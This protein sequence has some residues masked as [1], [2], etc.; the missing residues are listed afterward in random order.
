[1]AS[2]WRLEDNLLELVLS[3]LWDPLNKICFSYVYV[4][5]SV[6]LV[7]EDALADQKNVRP[8]PGAGVKDGC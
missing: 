2:M 5:L 3:F 4:S 7:C 6:C 1:M 8:L